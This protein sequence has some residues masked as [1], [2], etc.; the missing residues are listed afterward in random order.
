MLKLIAG[1]TLLLLAGCASAPLSGTIDAGN[2]HVYWG[3]RSGSIAFAIVTQGDTAGNHNAYK[4][5][6]QGARYQ[7]SVLFPGQAL[8][9]YSDGKTIQIGPQNFNLKQG[10]FFRV[11]LTDR[12]PIIRQVD[13][14]PGEQVRSIVTLD[15]QL[16]GATQ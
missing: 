9:F 2:R 4:T 3:G 13:I 10:R 8:D 12:S 7:G 6:L 16:G 15:E 14:P 11:S 1:A 5:T